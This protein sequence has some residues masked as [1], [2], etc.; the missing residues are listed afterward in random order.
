MIQSATT[1][2]ERV[3]ESRLGTLAADAAGSGIGSPC[4][5]VIGA[6]AALR[7]K[8]RSTMVGWT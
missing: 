5:V 1:E 7:G 4:I 6:V 3:V 8:L 2:N